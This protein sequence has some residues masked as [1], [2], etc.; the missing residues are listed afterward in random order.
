MALLS[1]SAPRQPSGSALPE[2][3]SPPSP[4]IHAP[5]PRSQNSKLPP[6]GAIHSRLGSASS[7]YTPRQGASHIEWRT[8][9]RWVAPKKKVSIER[10]V[11][12]MAVQAKAAKVGIHKLTKEDIEALSPAELK[13]LRGY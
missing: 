11:K 3:N 2:S 4:A 5:A 9:P 12:L 6:A 8:S 10:Q 7:S 1:C 13:E